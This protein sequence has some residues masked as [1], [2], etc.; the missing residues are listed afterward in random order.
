MLSPVVDYFNQE[1]SD[2]FVAGQ[3][4]PLWFVYKTN[5]SSST[6]VNLNVII[7]W[8]FKLHCRVK[9][10]GFLSEGFTSK[11][12]VIEGS[13]ISPFLFVMYINGLIKC[14]REEGVGCY[15]GVNCCGCLLFADDILLL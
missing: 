3:S 10:K 8:H 1:E 2:I 4:K 12:G 11:S 7:N 15:I 9:W 5:G 14:L 6:Y 13:T